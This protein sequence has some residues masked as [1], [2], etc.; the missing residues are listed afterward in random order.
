LLLKDL[1]N[2]DALTS[3]AEEG[4]R[5]KLKM[6]LV[7]CRKAIPITGRGG[8]GGC[9]MLRIPHC[10]DNLLPCSTL[11]KLFLSVSAALIYVMLFML[12]KLKKI[13]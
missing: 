9:Q 4:E 10:L 3:S 7:P 2:I 8:I 6:G 13:Q 11:Q 12:D 5:E 1:I